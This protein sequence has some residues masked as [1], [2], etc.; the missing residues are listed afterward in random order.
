MPDK[1][2]EFLMMREEELIANLIINH[3]VDGSMSGVG[4]KIGKVNG[5]VDNALAGKRGITV[6]KNW[7]HV[8]AF[9]VLSVRI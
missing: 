8:L 4:G 2:A 9:K 3:N 6:E 5:L 7:H 1:H